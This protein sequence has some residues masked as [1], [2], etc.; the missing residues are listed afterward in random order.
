MFSILLFLSLHCLVFG[1]K[2]K[3]IQYSVQYVMPY[4][5][6]HIFYFESFRQMCSRDVLITRTT[7]KLLTNIFNVQE[8]Q[9]SIG[10][11]SPVCLSHHHSCTGDCDN[12]CLGCQFSHIF[13]VEGCQKVTLAPQHQN[14]LSPRP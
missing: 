2:L 5:K 3:K 10:Y 11:L 6:C 9:H 4:I 1:K 12:L 8:V 13:L 14:R 7:E